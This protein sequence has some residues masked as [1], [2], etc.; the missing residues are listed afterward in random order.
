MNIISK[1]DK[2]ILKNLSEHSLRSVRE[3]TR[4]ERVNEVH[5]K[6][7]DFNQEQRYSILISNK[8]A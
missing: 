1:V 5:F 3:L 6:V 8:N 2:L 4:N 7:Y